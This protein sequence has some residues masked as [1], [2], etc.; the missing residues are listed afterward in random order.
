MSALREVGLDL[1]DAN[2]LRSNEF[3]THIL[4]LNRQEKAAK[5]KE[6]SSEQERQREHHNLD[7][8]ELDFR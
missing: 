3:L 2:P 4:Y 6:A 7:Q 5:V 1:A 8:Q